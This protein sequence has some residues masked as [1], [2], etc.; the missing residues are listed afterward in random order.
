MV[1][2]ELA[3]DLVGRYLPKGAK[4][5]DP[6]CGTGRLLAAAE[7]AAM[8]VGIDVNPLAWLL[9]TAKLSNSAPEVIGNIADDLARAKRRT[10]SMIH[11]EAPG[12][13]VEW[14]APE[15]RRELGRIVAWINA[16]ALPEP[17]RHLVA[18]A[19]SATV[20]EVSFARQSGWKLHRLASTDRERFSTCP[21]ARL[22]RRLRYCEAELRR[23]GHVAG[24]NYVALAHVASLRSP[25]HPVRA[26][27]P[28][29]A[30]LTSPPYGDSKTTVQYG[31]ASALS[32]S[33]VAHIDGFQ[34]LTA[35]GGQIDAQCLGGT[36][37]PEARPELNNLHQYWSGAREKRP[38]RLV[39]RF[40]AQYSEACDAI[41]DCIKLGG[42][43]VF[44]VG[45]RSVGGRRVRL[46]DFTV[47]HL[48]SRGFELVERRTRGLHQKRVPRRI[49]RFGHSDSPEMRE[50]GVIVTISSEIV[51]VLRKSQ[52]V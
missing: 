35:T 38:A 30:C 34:Q 52:R 43:A 21:W 31:A 9:T 29:D 45:R 27:G 51:L 32:L 18:A 2:D 3:I 41:A 49:N 25:K 6:F 16:L 1:A 11:L 14:F 28:Y 40:L 37:A 7:S 23:A 47:D 24:R 33:V 20:R 17:E 50:R 19:L 13:Q 22:E 48:Q 8:R 39:S 36:T 42:I 44:V 4:V 46:D 12:R 10:R 15:I 26:L 5:L